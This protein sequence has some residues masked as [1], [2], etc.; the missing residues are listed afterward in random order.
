MLII[1]FSKGSVTA[2]LAFARL[3]A[4]G[5]PPPPLPTRTPLRPASGPRAQPS[6]ALAAGGS[7]CEDGRTWP[8]RSGGRAEGRARREAG[9]EPG[10][11]CGAR[12]MEAPD[13]LPGPLWKLTIGFQRGFYFCFCFLFSLFFFQI[14]FI[15]SPRHPSCSEW[16]NLA[17]LQERRSWWSEAALSAAR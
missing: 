7:R 13:S 15:S 12:S 6:S 1:N 16:L 2:T 4:R 10:A 14:F 8:E 17:P 9:S 3:P 11:G 5:P